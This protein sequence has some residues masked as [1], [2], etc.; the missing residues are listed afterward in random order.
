ME[1]QNEQHNLSV[2]NRKRI[3]ATKIDSVDGFS[4]GRITLTY[5]GGKITVSGSDLKIVAFSKSTGAFSAVGNIDSVT[6]SHIGA[7]VKRLFK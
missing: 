2:E 4:S 1:Q 3:T 6:Y 7:G 5:A